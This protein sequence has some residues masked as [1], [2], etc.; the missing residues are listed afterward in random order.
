MDAFWIKNPAN[1]GPNT[2]KNKFDTNDETVFVVVELDKDGDYN[3]FDGKIDDMDIDA[4]YSSIRVQVL[5]QDEQTA[6]LVY[7]YKVQKGADPD[8]KIEGSTGYAVLQ[9]LDPS[10]LHGTIMVA[11]PNDENVDKNALSMSIDAL[12]KAGYEYKYQNDDGTLVA[13]MGDRIYTFT[14]SVIKLGKVTFTESDGNVSIVGD[15]SCY[16]VTGTEITLVLQNSGNWAKQGKDLYRVTASGFTVKEVKTDGNLMT[17]KMTADA[18]V[19]T[20]T[21]VTVSWS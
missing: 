16:V 20:A 17:V 21:T 13:M 1:T 2:Y 10:T 6:E 8:N 5:K 12:K 15:D 7:I 11:V 3:I 4:D 18:A 9:S 14:M 19:T